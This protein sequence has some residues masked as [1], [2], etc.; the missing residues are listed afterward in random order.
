MRSMASALLRDNAGM[1][2]QLVQLEAL[3]MQGMLCM[4]Q[5]YALA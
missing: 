2:A 3:H 5:P 4:R 1:Y